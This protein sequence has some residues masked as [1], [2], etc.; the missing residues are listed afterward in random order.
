MN[1]MYSQEM[2]K[3]YSQEVG[4]ASGTCEVLSE[5]KTHLTNLNMVHIGCTH[6]K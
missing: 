1:K 2:H 6:L 4:S 3:M 5:S